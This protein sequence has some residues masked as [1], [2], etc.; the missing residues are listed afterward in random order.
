MMGTDTM[1]DQ[2]DILIT[3]AMV[4]DGRAAAPAAHD[5]AIQGRHIAAIGPDLPRA[6]AARVIDATGLWLMPGL[7]DIHTHFDLEVELEPGLPEA[8]RHGTT[9][10]VVANCSIGL[11]FGAQRVDG[12]DPIVDCFAR[13]EN[14]PKHILQK[15]ADQVTW[16]DSADYLAHFDTLAL[17]PNIVPM[18]PHS[19][20]RIEV[21][22]LKDSVAR[23][24]SEDEL[25]RMEALLEKGMAEGYIGFSTDALPFHYLANDPNRQHRIPGQYGSYKEIKRLTDIVRRHGRVWQ[26]T[27]PKDS[28][29][30]VL[31]TFLLTSGRLFGRTLKITAVAAMDVATNRTIVKQGLVL[32]RLLNS[33]L[34]KGHFRLQALAAPFKVWSEGPLTP[35][36]EEIPELRQLNE[37]DLEDR[38]ARL[39][40][41]NDPDFIVRF[42][43]MWRHG[44][45]G[46]TIA[47]L[48][49]LLGRE[50]LALS[51]QLG[52]MVID[53]CPVE[54]WSGQP[55]DAIYDRLVEYQKT[56]GMSGATT[57]EETDAFAAFPDPIVDDAGFM[58]H[59]LRA[60]DT[61]L[62]WYTISANRDPA[63][64]KRLLNE[65]QM[66]PGF[67]D[68]GAHLTNMAFYD[69]NL[70]ALKIASEDGA[71]AVA[72]M[73]RRLT[74]E[75]AAFFGIDAGR[76][77]VGAQAD[78]AIVDPAALKTYDG[79]A[80]IQSLYRDRFEHT[81]LVNRSDGVVSYVLIAGRVAWER[82]GFTDVFGTERLGRVLTAADHGDDGAAE[83][84]KAAAE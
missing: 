62:Y 30:G 13:V 15:V 26:A 22:G 52:D 76:L 5:I 9:T 82:D 46:L 78:I 16:D 49:R 68:S 36:A 79:E 18:I 45:S 20:L 7:L 70:R 84:L 64:I 55:M 38:Q 59:L 34:L 75:P 19:M 72:R 50:D 14:V 80:H 3:G 11:A 10:A 8:V 24:P 74:R 60:Y 41:L 28:P 23:D 69:G 43:R 65:P 56:A 4:F 12:Q 1:T 21:M 73:V 42:R 35:L 17:G 63:V 67:N 77:E 53:R 33:R 25:Q 31:R 27:P 2:W 29:I 54:S 32:T 83:P 39:D 81:Q 48:K 51:R 58:L 37:P 66:L 6:H 40:L 47:N 71:A 57:P 44:K 61:D